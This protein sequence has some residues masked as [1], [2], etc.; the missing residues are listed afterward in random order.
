MATAIVRRAG[1]RAGFAFA[2]VAL[3][4]GG[5]AQAQEEGVVGEPVKWD[6]ARVTK[7]AEDLNVAVED[8]VQAMRESPVQ[9]QAAQRVTWYDL[10]EDLRLISNSTMHLQAILKEGEGQEETR[11]TFERIGSLRLD[12]EEKGR[13]SEI[14]APVMDALVKAGSIHNLMKPY[15]YGKR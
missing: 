1:L 15:Y 4:V 6:Q 5:A 9:N 14:P 7:Y 8:A 10:K 12:A 3:L 2:A 11:A 13:R